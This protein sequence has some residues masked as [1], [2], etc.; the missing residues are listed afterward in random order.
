MDNKAWA[1]SE[2]HNSSDWKASSWPNKKAD[3]G[4]AYMSSGSDLAYTFGQS[5]T[6]LGKTVDITSL[7]NPDK[8][9]ATNPEGWKITWESREN[10]TAGEGKYNVVL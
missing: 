1:V 5:L 8:N 7:D 3:Y 4:T 10:C 9:N 6:N 2:N